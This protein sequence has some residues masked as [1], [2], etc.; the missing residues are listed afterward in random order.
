[1]V[2]LCA[3]AL[4][5]AALVAAAGN[6]QGAWHLLWSC[7]VATAMMAIGLA[8][9][10]RAAVAAALLFHLGIGLPAWFAEVVL[11]RGTFGAATLDAKLLLTSIAVHLL[12]LIAGV[13]FMSRSRI[14]ASAILIALV[15]LFGMIPIAR[16]FT[17]PELNVNL[18]FGWPPLQ[19]VGHP[20]LLYWLELLLAIGTCALARGFW[21]LRIA[22]TAT[23]SA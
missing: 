11:S 9:R 23:T 18:A 22:Q 7:H 3:L 16:W 10:S 5:A 2:L 15:L 21:N 13:L 12:P 6:A 1:V 19:A 17:P 14:P 4:H 20:D 8:C